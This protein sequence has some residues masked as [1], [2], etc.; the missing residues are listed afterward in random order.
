M[1]TIPKPG[2]VWAL[3]F[4]SRIFMDLF[5]EL[6]RLAVLKRTR[7]LASLPQNSQNGARPRG[8]CRRRKRSM[9]QAH[10]AAAPRNRVLRLGRQSLDRSGFSFS[11]KEPPLP[12]P[13]WPGWRRSPRPPRALTDF[14][15]PTPAA[16][17]PGRRPHSSQPSLFINSAK[18]SDGAVFSDGPM[19]ETSGNAAFAS[20][21]TGMGNQ[22]GRAA[23][24]AASGGRGFALCESGLWPEK[25]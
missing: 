12:S 17:N 22:E 14:R 6:H 24:N 4:P 5:G 7:G 13:K 25:H 21:A 10:A 16:L 23:L 3:K 18:F 9:A 11:P 2:S 8:E 15:R 19:M 20:I 1:S